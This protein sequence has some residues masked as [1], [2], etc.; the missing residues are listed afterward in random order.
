MERPIPIL[1]QVADN[2]YLQYHSAKFYDN[3]WSNVL[4]PTGTFNFLSYQQTDS[5]QRIEYDP[6]DGILYRGNFELGPT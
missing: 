3:I 6:L 1:R 5:N 4:N 2:V